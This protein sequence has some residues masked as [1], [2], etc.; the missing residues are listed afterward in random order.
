MNIYCYCELG[1]ELY[2][3][4]KKQLLQGFEAF[5]NGDCLYKYI[6]DNDLTRESDI[7]KNGFIYP[8]MMDEPFDYWCKETDRFYRSKSEAI[9]ARWCTANKIKWEYEPFT[10]RFTAKKSYTPDFWLPD[11]YQF[12]EVKGVW[13]GAAKKKM[14][15][16]VDKGFRLLLVPDYLI[17]KL[18][19]VW[20]NHNTS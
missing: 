13:S 10:I 1:F 11:Y 18:R 16:A 9:F 17:R 6:I 12:V 3:K 2:Y 20:R 19:R 4:Q 15:L 14:R 8:S 7:H 5:C